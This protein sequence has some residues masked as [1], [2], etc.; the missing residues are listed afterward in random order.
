VVGPSEAPI[1]EGELLQH[2]GVDGF[3]EEAGLQGIEDAIGAV[4]RTTDEVEV[5]KEEPST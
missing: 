1:Q 4:L 3:V 2:H 5:A